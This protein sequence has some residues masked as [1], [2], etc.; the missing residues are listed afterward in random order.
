[1]LDLSLRMVRRLPFAVASVVATT[2]ATAQCR[3][4]ISGLRT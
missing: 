4:V 2:V 1:V 3:P